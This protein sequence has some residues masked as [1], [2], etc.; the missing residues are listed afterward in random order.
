MAD[1]IING[2]QKTQNVKLKSFD[3]NDIYN[4]VEEEIEIPEE[5]VNP[6]TSLPNSHLYKIQESHQSTSPPQTS[7]N[8]DSA[9][10]QSFVSS[11]GDAKVHLFTMFNLN[12][13]R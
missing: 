12:M 6:G 9:S 11:N 5:V 13:Y 3:L 4:V 8:S 2:G 7:G 10:V 1:S